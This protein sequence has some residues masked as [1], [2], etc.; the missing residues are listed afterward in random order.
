MSRSTS[1]RN[2]SSPL[3][4]ASRK[5]G[6]SSGESSNASRKIGDLLEAF[7]LHEATAW[8]WNLSLEVDLSI[9]RGFFI[10]P[11]VRLE[12]HVA[13]IVFLANPGFTTKKFTATAEQWPFQCVEGSRLSRL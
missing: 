12:N 11:Q 1:W 8:W 9:I 10:P 4:A 13:A 6:R 2:A 7:S 3:H 5:V